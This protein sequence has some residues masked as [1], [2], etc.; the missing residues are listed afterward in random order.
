MSRSI[1]SLLS[2]NPTVLLEWNHVQRN[3]CA[4]T[5]L[6]QTLTNYWIS[7]RGTYINASTFYQLFRFVI[8]QITHGM[9]RLSFTVH[10]CHANEVST[11]LFWCNVALS[12][13]NYVKSIAVTTATNLLCR[14]S[15]PTGFLVLTIFTYGSLFWYCVVSHC[16]PFKLN[17]LHNVNSQR[18]NSL[19]RLLLCYLTSSKY[20]DFS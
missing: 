8:G 10:Q 13:I 3:G 5:A 18:I 17:S 12:K 11:I 20:R 7:E 16:P 9:F 15:D 1:D 6:Q 2:Q 19:Q 4:Q 14:I